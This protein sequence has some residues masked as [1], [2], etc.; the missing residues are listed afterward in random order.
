MDSA[1]SD[2]DD[3]AFQPASASPG[4]AQRKRQRSMEEMMRQLETKKKRIVSPKNKSQVSGNTEFMAELQIMMKSC[5]EEATTSLWQ[6]VDSKIS[7]YETKLEI[8]EGAI[9]ERDQRIVQLETDLVRCHEALEK[10]EEHLDE[11]ERHSRSVN[12]ILT[13]Q[14]FG[15][16]RDGE[17]IAGMTVAMINDNYPSMNVCRDDFSVIHR[18]ARDNTVIC[19][20]KSKELR[21][22]IYDGRL[23]MRFQTDPSNRLYVNELKK[24]TSDRRPVRTCA[25]APPELLTREGRSA[26]GV[27]YNYSVSATVD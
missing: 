9:F 25:C 20:F 11:M 7:S 5:I 19:S 21:N 14:K 17:D 10:C 23:R 4:P 16:R 6:K 8:M 24:L 2:S 1:L 12:L 3:T 18:L 26:A 22:K 27:V 15:K 13:S